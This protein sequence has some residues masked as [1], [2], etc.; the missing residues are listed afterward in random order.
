T[1]VAGF[2]M[3]SRGEIQKHTV[4][5]LASSHFVVHSWPAMTCE[6]CRAACPVD[7]ESLRPQYS[8]RPLPSSP[9]IGS[10][11]PPV[12]KG[13]TRNAVCHRLF[14]LIVPFPKQVFI[15]CIQNSMNSTLFRKDFRY[16]SVELTGSDKM[17]HGMQKEQPQHLPE[18]FNSDWLR[19]LHQ[20]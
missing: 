4:N 13:K 11:A 15:V 12:G 17:R 14:R 3:Q 10:S 5:G 20:R 9:G 1:R 8:F 18:F 2:D 6:P 16:V 19:S 7:R